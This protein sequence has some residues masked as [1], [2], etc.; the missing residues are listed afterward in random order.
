[1]SVYHYEPFY[2]F[3][4]FFTE[5]FSRL[6]DSNAEGSVVK[7]VKPRM[8]LHENAEKNVV[9]ATFELPGLTKDGVQIDLHDNRLTVSGE[10]KTSE[11]REE[12]GYAVRERSSGKFFR[13][14][15]LPAGVK[16]EEIKA[17]MENGVLTVTF[18][19]TGKEA[20]RKKIA[21]SSRL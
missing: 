1:M 4:R 10:T 18:P 3:D 5:V 15:Q 13:T 6:G 7:S 14:L 11:E 21:I 20:E 19:K 12:R 16:E 9:T 17:S 8:D 2:N